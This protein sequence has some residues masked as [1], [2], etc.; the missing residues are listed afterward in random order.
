MR[1]PTAL[2]LA[3]LRREG[4]TPGIV[5]RRLPRCFITVDLYHAFDLVAVRPDRPGVLGV[6]ATGGTGGNHA[7]RVRKLLENPIVR[8]WLAAGNGA[9]VWSWARRA[10]KLECRRQVL[11][12]ADTTKVEAVPLERRKRR[13]PSTQLELFQ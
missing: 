12:L 13:R 7:A 3:Q 6:Q 5:E 11:T 9:E 4:W 10:G 2:T 8:I 1:S